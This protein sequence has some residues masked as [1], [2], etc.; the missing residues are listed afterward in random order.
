MQ[1]SHGF[2][3]YFIDGEGFVSASLETGE[4]SP[5]TSS[6]NEATGANLHHADH[7]PKLRFGR[8]FDNLDP[9][10]ADD[11]KLV[12]LGQAMLNGPDLGDHTGLPAGYT[13][14]AQFIA[15]DVSFDENN[16]IPAA[17][18]AADGLIQ[19]RTPSLDLDSLYGEGPYSD[20]D[21]R[22]YD[23]YDSAKLKIG[24]T[25]AASPGSIDR[26]YWNDL[27]REEGSP[28]A[29]IKD[30]RNDDN[31]ALA[32]THVAFIKFHNKVVDLLRDKNLSGRELFEEAQKKV[33]EHYQW[34]ILDD[35]LPKIVDVEI[36]QRAIANRANPEHFRPAEK[37]VPFMPV[38]FSLAAFRL[39]HSM[40]RDTYDWNRVFQS[41]DQ[42]ET[43]AATLA[44]IVRLTGFRGNLA[45]SLKLPSSWIID[46]TRF[47]DFTGHN[48]IANNPNFNWSKKID[49]T[50][51]RALKDF[52]IFF[53]HINEERFRSLAVIDLIRGRRLKLPSGQEVARA[54]KVPPMSAI[55]LTQYPHGDVVSK[56]GFDKETPLW[57]YILKEAQVYRRGE[58]LGPVGSY[59]LAETFVQLIRA[60]RISIL[61]DENF[62]KDGYFTWRPDLGQI[63][64]D[65]FAM[66]DLLVFAQVV[67]PLGA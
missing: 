55:Q 8:M 17:D 64:P 20:A 26:E 6:E 36:L 21:R 31:L 2:T 58:R 27:R 45:G 25:T 1:K 4:V 24:K 15:H 19:L 18:V 48:G 14:L 10:K 9:H 33:V 22:L 12:T 39:G 41:P 51:V 32:Q 57:Y 59:I 54:L 40:V 23:E 44:D 16:N 56:T 63:E 3:D 38:E 67:N 11:D 61:K 46:W 28:R 34:I 37:G 13:Y 66:A 29:I 65:R 60:S 35:L 50:L 43:H 42:L 53:R 7:Q 52:E 62:T 5:E 49:T 30:H 47:Y